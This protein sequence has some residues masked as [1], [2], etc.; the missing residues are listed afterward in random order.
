MKEQAVLYK[1]DLTLPL[2]DGR[3]IRN[4][5]ALPLCSTTGMQCLLMVINTRNR[6]GQDEEDSLINFAFQAFQT[7]A[8]QNEVA[9]LATTDGLT[10]LFNHR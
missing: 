10:G 4:F 9:K 5:M 7:L 6:F 8:L 3:V 1:N 2:S